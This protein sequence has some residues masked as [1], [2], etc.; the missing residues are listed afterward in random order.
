MEA[1]TPAANLRHGS[2]KSGQALLNV[3]AELHTPGAGAYKQLTDQGSAPGHLAVVQGLLWSSLGMN[4][5][6]TLLASLHLFCTGLTSAGL[7]LALIT[8]IEAQLVLRDLRPYFIEVL[9]KEPCKPGQAYSFTPVSEIA[10]MRHEKI[11]SR[12]FAN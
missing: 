4:I 2:R 12:L 6:D 3:H 1:M 8:H 9:K 10:A 7:R 5:G 11:S